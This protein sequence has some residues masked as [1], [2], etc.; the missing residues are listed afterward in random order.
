ML[1]TLQQVLD[2]IKTLNKS[3]KNTA[4]ASQE[5]WS[6]WHSRHRLFGGTPTPPKLRLP[7]LARPRQYIVDLKSIPGEGHF[8][9]SVEIGITV[10][11]PASVVWLHGKSLTIHRVNNLA[12]ESVLPAKAESAGDDFI[13]IAADRELV[14]GDARAEARLY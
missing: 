13:A 12:G 7:Q 8:T 3:E 6:L 2:L 4:I 11:Q 10:L 1:P 14:P 9:G 5:S